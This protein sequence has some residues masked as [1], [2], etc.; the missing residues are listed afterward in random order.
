MSQSFFNSA[1]EALKAN[2]SYNAYV[3]FKAGEGASVSDDVYK[4]VHGTSSTYQFTVATATEANKLF[5]E[6]DILSVF[7][8]LPQKQVMRLTQGLNGLNQG[9]LSQFDKTHARILLALYVSSTLSDKGVR[10][11]QIARI[12]GNVR[13]GGSDNDQ[14]LRER[15]N[16]LFKG[17]HGLNTVLSKVSNMTG[18]TGWAEVINVTGS[19]GYGHNRIVHLNLDHAFTRAFLALVNKSTDAQLANLFAEKEKK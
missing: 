18:K 19:E 5:D 6:S 7:A 4:L 15:V 13:L 2:K 12:A 11:S 1:I 3:A 14:T 8:N 9:L 17:N 10:S 16:A